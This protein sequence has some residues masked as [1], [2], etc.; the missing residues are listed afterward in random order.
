MMY[1]LFSATSE[2]RSA[3]PDAPVVPDRAPRRRL[4]LPV[5]RPL[6]WRLATRRPAS[7]RWLT[8]ART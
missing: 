1:P 7:L 4:R 2:A 6:R 3:L 8:G 5:A